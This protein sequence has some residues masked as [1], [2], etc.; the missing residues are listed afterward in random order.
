VLI[1]DDSPSIRRCLA[2]AIEPWG[3]RI[4]EA[5]DG[6]EACRLAFAGLPELILLDQDMPGFTG[7]KAASILRAD[8]RF[9]RTAIVIVSGQSE[10]KLGGPP[11]YDAWI[12]K[13]FSAADLREQLLRKF[14]HRRAN[15]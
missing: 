14:A 8:R 6:E 1:A 15:R 5:A 2:F 7:V 9:D 13:P 11:P 10:E 3:S 12:G 4:V